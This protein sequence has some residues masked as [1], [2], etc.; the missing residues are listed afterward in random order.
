MKERSAVLKHGLLLFLLAAAL[1]TV[2]VLADMGPK[3]QLTVRVENGP[4][5]LYY[6]DLLEE[7]EPYPYPDQVPGGL[8]GNYGEELETLDQDLLAAFTAAVPEGWHAC[9]AQGDLVWGRIDSRDG[10]FT[11]G[12][13]LPST[14]RILLVTKSRETFLS[15]PME[16]Q[17]LQCS[18][19]VDWAAK[20]VK[21]PP[22]WKGYIV[23][24]LATFLPTLAIEGL[25][26]RLWSKRNA[27]VFL[28]VNLLTQGGPDPL[29]QSGDRPLW[30]ILGG[31]ASNRLGVC[32][33]VL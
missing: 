15:E 16:R 24:F 10:C 6:L 3:P 25:L 8:K 13:M 23:Q 31:D 27:L 21:S 5:E 22:L 9:V 32:R 14:F 1:L 2:P 11:F 20:T 19:T 12:Y 33:P 4:E 26:F 28:G 18:A 17:A 7:G 29:G 30:H